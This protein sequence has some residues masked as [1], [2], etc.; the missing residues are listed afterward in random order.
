MVLLWAKLAGFFVFTGRGAQPATS[1]GTIF[2]CLKKDC[3]ERQIKGAAAPLNPLGLIGPPTGRALCAPLR[4]N[5]SDA[6]KSAAVPRSKCPWG[7]LR[8]S[9]C[10]CVLRRD[11]GAKRRRR[12]CPWG[13]LPRLRWCLRFSEV[14]ASQCAMTVET[15]KTYATTRLPS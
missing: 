13:A 6:I 14:I 11:G 8:L 9:P 10:L 2:L 15:L 12:K 1:G 3:G 4:D 5:I 7:A